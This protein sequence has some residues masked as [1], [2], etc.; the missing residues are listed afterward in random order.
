[1]FKNWD[2]NLFRGGH[3]DLVLGFISGPFGMGRGSWWEE[4]GLGRGLRGRVWCGW[5]YVGN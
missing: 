1:M 2:L 4:S 3:M 5:G